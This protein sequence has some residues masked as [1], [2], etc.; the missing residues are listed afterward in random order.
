MKSRSWNPEALVARGVFDSL[1]ELDRV[2][3]ELDDARPGPR[4]IAASWVDFE[5][6]PRVRH[7]A[8]RAETFPFGMGYAQPVAAGSG[9]AT[10][11]QRSP[12]A[13]AEPA[14]VLCPWCAL[15]RAMQG[16]G[17]APRTGFVSVARCARHCSETSAGMEQP[18]TTPKRS[19]A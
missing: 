4:I 14:A 6:V 15:E 10:S 19:A 7:D 3:C 18:A 13:V 2:R 16:H 9:C 11:S 8:G 12:E 5:F 17:A 1:D